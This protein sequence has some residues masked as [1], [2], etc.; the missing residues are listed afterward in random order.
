[1]TG[2]LYGVGVGPGDPELV[3]I[4]AARLIGAADV[5]AFHA[6]GHGRS[7]ARATAAPYLR[8][9]QIE[10]A[11]IYPVTRGATD[12]PGGYDG[13]IADFYAES[14]A[15]LAVHLAAGRD[16]VLLAEGDPT[17]YSSYMHMH[18]RLSADFTCV[19]VP[20]VTSVAA[21]AAAAGTPLVEGNEILTI[22]PAT[23]PPADLV[24]Q[25]RTTDAAAILKVS[26]DV[27]GAREAVRSAGRLDTARYV[28]RASHPEQQVSPL[29]EIDA[30]QV[31]YMATILLPG[32]VASGP[33]GS[34]ETACRTG[35]GEVVVIGLGP[36]DDRW[37]TP[38]ASAELAAADHLVGYERYVAQVPVHPGQQRHASDNRVEAERAEF[39]LSLARGGER[40]AVVSSGDPGVF[41]MAAAVLEVREREGFKEVPVRIVAGVTAAQAVAAR[42][43][44]PLGHDY[45]VI[46]LS[47]QLKPWPIIRRRVVAALDS[48]LVIALYNPASKSRRAHLDEVVGLIGEHRNSDTPIVI[49]RAVGS[50]DES[51]RVVRLGDFDPAVV[52]MRTLLIIGSTQTRI[53]SASEQPL[54][55]T[56]R[57][58]PP[59]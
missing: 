18:K 14:A 52:D 1:M 22:L 42:A 46:S 39:A 51:V 24:R 57:T 47:D 7:L 59:T 16:V 11:L 25:L 48:D 4:K 41:A 23:L 13:A 36:G 26:R 49:G 31:P 5:V 30:E 28:Q 29:A 32:P 40:V 37:L 3:T 17:L 15:R 27:E 20:G 43:G 58:Y 21:A 19:I 12:H 6:A 54:T 56:P 9:G 53:D 33:P 50:A 34:A 35:T 55:F 45:C 38:E 10:E 44:A 8:P 2:T